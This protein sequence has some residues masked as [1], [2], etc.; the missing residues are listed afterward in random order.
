M[1]KLQSLKSEIKKISNSSQSVICDLQ[2]L[3][4]HIK[5]A[6]SSEQYDILIFE[7][8]IVLYSMGQRKIIRL[9]LE[10]LE[11]ITITKLLKLM[12]DIPPLGISNISQESSNRNIWLNECLW[13][14][15]T[16]YRNTTSIHEI[17]KDLNIDMLDEN[18]ENSLFFKLK[19]M[20][21]ISQNVME[22]SLKNLDSVTSEN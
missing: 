5:Q 7:S 4:K 2:F 18:D 22:N 12:E 8:I 3:K 13:Y 19:G 16:R 15:A 10:D 14:L 20:I 11:E 17:C 1:E 9:C 21:K 6:I